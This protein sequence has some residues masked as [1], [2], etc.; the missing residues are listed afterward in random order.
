MAQGTDASSEGAVPNRNMPPSILPHTSLSRCLRE[1][2][3][4]GGQWRKGQSALHGV[5]TPGFL[6]DRETGF[7]GLSIC[8]FSKAPLEKDA[9]DFLM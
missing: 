5:G 4:V 9:Y 3:K 2:E 1:H 7:S 8:P 6:L